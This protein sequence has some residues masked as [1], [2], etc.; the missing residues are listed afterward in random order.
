MIKFYFILSAQLLF[1]SCIDVI[2]HEEFYESVHLQRSG[3]FEFYENDENEKLQFSSDSAIQIWFSGEEESWEVA[4]CILNIQG[5]N[6]QLSVFRS[7][8]ANNQM[9]VYLNGALLQTIDRNSINFDDETTFYLLSAVMNNN[10]II[11]YLNHT[12]LMDEP[13]PWDDTNYSYQVG[14]TF[15]ENNN[16]TNLWY[17]YIDEIRL[18]N[19]PL[20]Q[21]II[22]FHYQYP[23]KVS[24]S[25]N[26]E[27]LEHL[28]GLWNFKINIV[29]EDDPSY[30]FQDINNHEMYTALYTSNT[31]Q[32][33]ELS[34]I[35]R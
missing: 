30:I 25:Y 18:W 12:R 5:E 26:E 14:A 28:I 29:G 19:T 27:Y 31:G 15:N 23:Y 1:Y 4:P 2:I 6:N 34:T 17:G 9:T 16:V 21:D 10:Q 13:I 3:W 32:Q 11:L 20:T 22:C 24:S 8:N 35:G 33:N 7:L